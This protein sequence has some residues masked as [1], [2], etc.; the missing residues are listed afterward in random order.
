M[1][2]IPVIRCKGLFIDA[3]IACC[4]L[5]CALSVQAAPPLTAGT[6][7]KVSDSSGGFDFI[8]VDASANRL[9]LAQERGNAA[10][11]VFDLST[12]KLLRRV[13]T[14]TS[15]DAA[16]DLKHDAYYV[17]GNDP[18][19]ML[20]VSRKD[21]SVLG[22][23]PVPANTDLIAYDPLTQQVHESNDTA[24]EEWVINPNTKQIVTTIKFNGSGVEDLAFD[25][26]YKHLYQAIKGANMIAEVDPAGNRVLHQWPLAPDT[27]PHGIA[28]VSDGNGLLVACAGKLVLMDRSNGKI[29]DRADVPQGVD[30]MAYDPHTH[31]AYLASRMGELGVVRVNGDKLTSLGSV[32]DERG[33]HSVTFDPKTHAVWIAYGKGNECFVQPFTPT[34]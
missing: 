2:R 23:V 17:S 9:L 7:I 21:L 8:R 5:A 1:L 6:P 12:K 24:A 30:E 18:H 19:R 26:G 14:S 33:T 28:I 32:P 34:E 11:L 29:L 25:S 16:V 31:L 4:V 27:G 13:P 15:Q 22:D 10:F 20:I 3:G